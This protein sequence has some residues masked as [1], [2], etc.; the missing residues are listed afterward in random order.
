MKNIFICYIL[1]IITLLSSCSIKQ[2]PIVEENKNSLDNYL[3][4]VNKD[5]P[6]EKNY[7]PSD[8]VCIHTVDFIKR[9]NE[10]MMLNS[11]AFISYLSM[12]EDALKHDLELTIFSAYRSFEKQETLWNNNP[13]ENYVARAGHSE[14]QTGLAIDISR[15]DIG[16]TLNFMETEEYKYLV[17]NAHLYGFI[18]RYPLDK[19]MITGYLFEPWHF[20]YVGI[21]VATTIY[22]NN[23]TLEEYLS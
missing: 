17:N 15:K 12:Y 18:N 6:L 22:T 10:T 1:S 5:H 20:R 21:D 13:N 11:T 3:I 19:E 8:L 2:N 23:L 16:L 4:L 9:E 14:H 7:V